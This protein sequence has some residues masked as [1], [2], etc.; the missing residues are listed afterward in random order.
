MVACSSAGRTRGEDTRTCSATSTGH[1]DAG[2]GQ[3]DAGAGQGEAGAA[4]G[5]GAGKAAQGVAG[6]PEVVLQAKAAAAV[7]RSRQAVRALATFQTPTLFG[8]CNV[9]G[10]TVCQGIASAERLSCDVF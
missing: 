5:G 4:A 7:S 8:A 6:A 2:A 3:G 10:K 1:G 9:I